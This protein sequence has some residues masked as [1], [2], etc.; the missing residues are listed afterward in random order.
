MTFD[1]TTLQW[2]V[3]HL[4]KG[5]GRRRLAQYLTVF[6]TPEVLPDCSVSQLTELDWPAGLAEDVLA[7]ARQPWQVLPDL[8]R[9]ANWAARPDQYVLT[10]AMASYPWR[11]TETLVDPPPVLYVKGSLDVLDSLQLAIVGSRQPSAPNARLTEDWSTQLAARGLVITSGLARGIDAA[12]HRGALA[13]GQPTLAVLGSGLDCIY[14]AGHEALAADIVARSGALMSE[15]PPWTPPAAGNFPRR[16][17]LVAALSTAVLV[18]EGAE[19]SG[20]LITARLGAEYNRDV[21]VVPN[22]PFY[23]GGSGSNRLLK[24]GASPVTCVDD[25]ADWLELTGGNREDDQA[26]PLSPDQAR[27][28]AHIGT[29][30]TA[31]ETLTDAMDLPAS[32]LYEPLMALELSGYI[33]VEGSRYLRLRGEPG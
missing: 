6:G 5:I 16:N 1:Q 19:R 4:T 9:L 10:P 17:R 21:M 11:L 13:A 2:L 30:P 20:S 12:A 15:L 14:P 32:E 26:S 28:F 31:L 3:L 18:V 25:I 22:H 7:A 27:L 29:E 8:K 23:P 24:E 33:A